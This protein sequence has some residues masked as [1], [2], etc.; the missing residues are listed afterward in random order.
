MN[1]PPQVLGNLANSPVARA[2]ARYWWVILPIGLAAW[3]KYRERKERDGKASWIDVA[4]D[5]SPLIGAIGVVVTLN[6]MARQA[7]E[8]AQQQAAQA[9]RPRPAPMPARDA[10]FQPVAQAVPSAQDG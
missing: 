8:R 5:V 9:P 7:E 4:I 3:A 6:D 2:A 10:D 1:L